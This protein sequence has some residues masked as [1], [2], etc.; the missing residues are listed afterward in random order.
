MSVDLNELKKLSLRLIVERTSL[1][2]TMAAVPETERLSSESLQR[3][4]PRGQPLRA[5]SLS[6]SRTWRGINNRRGAS[7]SP[8]R[9][10]IADTRRLKPGPC[11]SKEPDLSDCVSGPSIAIA[12]AP[13][14]PE[15]RW[16]GGAALEEGPCQGVF[17]FLPARG[18]LPLATA[19]DA[20]P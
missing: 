3:F 6:T 12:P 1:I 7:A 15:T 9:G 14:E 20:E 16:P 8:A 11:K 5:K 2:E 17:A 19:P 4:R 18:T 13:F 10:S